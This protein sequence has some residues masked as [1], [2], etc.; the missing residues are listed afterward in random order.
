MIYNPQEYKIKDE[1]MK[2]FIDAEEI[3]DFINATKK[4]SKE[5]VR[6]IIQKSLNKER[7]S[8]EET[9]VLINADSPKLVEEIKKGAQRLKNEVYGDRIVLFAPLYIGN[10]CTNN[11][12][13][14]GFR[15]KDPKRLTV[16]HIHPKSRGGGHQWTN[17]V[18]A[19]S[20]C[21]TKKGY[22]LLKECN[23]RLKKRPKKPSVWGL[24]LTGLDEHG[25][26][27]WKRWIGIHIK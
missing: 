1:A 5:R 17:V 23:M 25:R 12:Q 3:W 13:Y 22:S 19:C 10:L 16:D 18:T 11:C 8:L 20:G 24:K 27:L 26:K 4:P 2:P 7:L 14:C 21:N 9:A 6:E 15:S